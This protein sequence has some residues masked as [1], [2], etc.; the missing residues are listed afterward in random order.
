MTFWNIIS[1][2]FWSYV[3]IAYLVALFSVISDLFRDKSVGG[4]AKAIWV[5]FLI[6]VP[7]VTVLVYLIA[8]GHGM[9]ERSAKSSR[10]AQDDTDNYIRSVAAT[11]P[12]AASSASPAEQ[13]TQ[14]KALHQSGAITQAEYDSIKATALGTT[15]DRTPAPV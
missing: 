2:F 15:P 11:A 8:R 6:F 3:L 4:F 10:Q 1:L 14:A 12:A 13:I 7:F 5:L 9:G